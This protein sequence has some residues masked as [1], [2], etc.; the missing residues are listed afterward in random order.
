[1][2][3]PTGARCRSS[4]HLRV[5]TAE[6]SLT[7]RAAEVP[8]LPGRGARGSAAAAAA[9]GG[10]A[11]RP[12]MGEAGP[13]PKEA[14]EEDEAAA[15]GVRDGRAGPRGVV[16]VLK[17][18]TGPGLS[19]AVPG[20]ISAPALPGSSVWGAAAAVTARCVWAMPAS[21]LAG[22]RPCRLRARQA[23]WLRLVRRE[24]PRG[25]FRRRGAA[26]SP[27]PPPPPPRARPRLW[28]SHSP[29]AAEALRLML[30][31]LLSRRET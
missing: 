26:V 25:G 6:P 28:P 4:T 22:S 15:V 12:A 30:W 7:P 18:R 3:C 8:A 14:P 23:R 27:C 17:V 29:G 31:F 20:R 24:W 11:V 9:P 10:L 21:T 2:L 16:R 13:G 1:M 5:A 19:G